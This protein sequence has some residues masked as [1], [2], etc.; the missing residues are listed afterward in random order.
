MKKVQVFPFILFILVIVAGC[1]T[2]PTNTADTV[3]TP[4]YDGKPLVIG[5]IGDSPEVRENNVEF[6]NITFKQLEEGNNLSS[7]FD[8]IMIMKEHLAEATEG[9]YAK[10]YKNPSMPYFFIE[11]TKSIVPFVIEELSYDQVSEINKL[12]YATGY[13]QKD[14]DKYQQWGYGLYNDKVNEPNIEDVYT[15]I[16]TTIASIEI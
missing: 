4:L 12:D 9:K 6:R 15:R 2:N 5:T 10:V 11:S 14:D 16:F 13:L 3:D 8:A 1:T 7:E